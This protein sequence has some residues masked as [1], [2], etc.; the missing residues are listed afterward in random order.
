M[1]S[2]G[3]GCRDRGVP[4]S[5]TQTHRG[6]GALDAGVQEA[7][8]ASHLGHHGL[9]TLQTYMEVRP[10]RR[11]EALSAMQEALG[12]QPTPNGPV[13]VKAPNGDDLISQLVAEDDRRAR[14]FDWES[15]APEP[16]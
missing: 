1:P 5:L 12:G 11:A 13:P 2:G 9:R 4:S 15:L 14:P 8:I 16:N 7:I 10:K 3:Q 6:N